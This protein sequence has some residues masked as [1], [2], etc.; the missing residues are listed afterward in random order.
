MKSLSVLAAVNVWKYLVSFCGS[1]VMI[2]FVV[3]LVLILVEMIWY[4]TGHKKGGGQS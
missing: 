2:F 4:H 1:V 3:S